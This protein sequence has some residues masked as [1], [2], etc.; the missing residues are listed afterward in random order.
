MRS[1]SLDIEPG[2]YTDSHERG[3]A[4]RLVLRFSSGEL[5]VFPVPGDDV[6]LEMDI[7][8]SSAGLALWKPVVR[9]REGLLVIAEEEID[10]ITLVTVR[11]GVPH[12]FRDIEI[13]TRD[14]AVDV[15]DCRFDL[16]VSTESGDVAIDGANDV[17]VTS[18][19][20]CVD[21]EDARSLVVHGSRGEVRCR[22]VHGVTRVETSSGP[23]VVDCAQGNVVVNSQSGDITVQ[24]PAGRLRVFSAT[25]DVDLEISGQFGLSIAGAEIEL[26]CETLAGTINAPGCT[27]STNAGPRRC[28]LHCGKGGKRLHIKSVSGDIDIDR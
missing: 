5:L 19:A 1:E 26:R 23:V 17:E 6:R 10:P 2:Y 4:E 21:V 12:G 14:G 27:V 16:L 8:G 11:V 22:D 13:H 3:D 20:G 25:G 28:A 18:G 9:R 15:R 7:R 24:K